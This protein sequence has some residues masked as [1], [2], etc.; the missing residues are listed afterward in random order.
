MESQYIQLIPKKVEKERKGTMNRWDKQKTNSK[1]IDL[2]LIISIITVNVNSPNIP[3]K[4]QNVRLDKKARST[5]ML[6]KRSEL[7]KGCKQFRNK[8]MEKINYASLKKS[9]VGILIS[10]KVSF[11]EYQQQ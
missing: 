5:Y 3:I 9:G 1:I 7:Y 4:K 11:K 6:S 10:H 8:I 2:S